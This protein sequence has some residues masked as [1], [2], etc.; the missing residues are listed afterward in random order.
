MPD[1]QSMI[2]TRIRKL[3]AK[4][5]SFHDDKKEFHPEPN[6]MNHLGQSVSLAIE[7]GASW[8]VCCAAMLHDIAKNTPDKKKWAQH[9]HRGAMLISPDVPEQV[10]W[11]VASHMRIIDYNNGKMRAHKRKAFEEERWFE[12]LQRLHGYDCGARKA[13]G[14]HIPWDKIY[15]ALDNIDPRPSRAY[16]MVGMQAS[17]KSTVGASYV[18]ASRDLGDWWRPGVERSC[19]DDIRLICGTGPGA[20]RHQ[21]SS[22]NMIQR[23]AIRMAL[24]RGQ[25]ILIDN[26]HNTVARR[27]N[28]LE[29]LRQEFPDIYVTAVFV[30]APL[31]T[32]IA[33]NRTQAGRHRIQIPDAVLKQF[34]GDL[35]SGFGGKVHNDDV[36]IRQLIKEGFDHVDV[37]RTG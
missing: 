15:E 26:C 23:M 33:R 28:M 13:S 7:D 6:V 29:W 18:D 9:A 3:I 24:G 19:K 16:M 35:V 14:M 36:I 5:A 37:K 20:F 27:R 21:E 17:G 22:V 32:C 4:T 8:E 1:V 11:L 34:H 2:P 30:Y 31:D 10:Q 12:D 25:E